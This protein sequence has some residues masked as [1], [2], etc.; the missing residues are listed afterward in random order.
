MLSST[1]IVRMACCAAVMI[2]AVLGCGRDRNVDANRSRI[3]EA[4]PDTVPLAGGAC[5]YAPLAF[6]AI[7]DS[8]LANRDVILHA[9]DSVP[10]A[11]RIC[12]LLRDQGDGRWR[13]TGSLAGRL[14]PGDTARVEGEVI[15][16]GTCTPCAIVTRSVHEM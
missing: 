14:V 12:H 8:V 1:R 6:T 15:E 5:S 2:V 7:V 10:A 16:S 13:A 4:E 11:A 3:P 9:V